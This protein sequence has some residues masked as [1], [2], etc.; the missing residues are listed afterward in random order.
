[1]PAARPAGSDALG[2]RNISIG[3]SRRPPFVFLVVGLLSGG[4]VCLL[5]LNTVLAEGT[6]QVTSLQQ[7]N[8]TLARQQQ[9]LQQ[10]VAAAQSPGAIAQQASQ[11]GMVPVSQPSFVN[12]ESGRI[13][14]KTPA[15]VTQVAN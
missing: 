5:L 11:L 7:A 9:E 4:L 1:V 3:A 14:D 15:L 8:A 10:E 13:Y 6:F 2:T 12:L